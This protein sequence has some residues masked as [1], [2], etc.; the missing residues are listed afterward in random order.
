[1]LLKR[2]LREKLG[3]LYNHCDEFWIQSMWRVAKTCHY[4]DGVEGKQF[5]ESARAFKQGNKED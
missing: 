2:A 5:Y 1:M 3:P 4:V